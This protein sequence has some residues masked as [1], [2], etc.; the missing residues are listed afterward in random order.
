MAERYTLNRAE[1]A[2]IMRQV[3]INPDTGCWEWQGKTNRNGYAWGQKGP[4]Q[5]QR[6]MHRV[7]V[8]DNMNAP[9]P[10]NMQADH[11]CRVRHC[12]NPEHF[13]IVTNAE[14]TMRQDHANRLK[15]HCKRGH[16]F[17]PENTTERRGRRICRECDRAR[18]TSA[19]NVPSAESVAAPTT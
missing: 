14:N 7:M 6:V 4:G 2:K 13:E 1:R 9:I 11:L 5:P 18:K 15:T 3:K 8:E 19:S 16:E 12:I 10:D 17:T